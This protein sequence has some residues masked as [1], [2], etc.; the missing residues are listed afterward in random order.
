M[1][2]NR[3]RKIARTAN[4]FLPYGLNLAPNCHN[5]HPTTHPRPHPSSTLAPTLAPKKMTERTQKRT[6]RS[7]PSPTQ[8]VTRGHR[9]VKRFHP[10]GTWAFLGH[11]GP[12]HRSP[13]RGENRVTLTGTGAKKRGH[14]MGVPLPHLRLSGCF[15]PAAEKKPKKSTLEAPFVDPEK[16]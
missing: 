8:R 9:R 13:H 12:N 16:R 10:D 1:P 3:S 14:G 2:V 6:D 4:F 11:D 5:P 7:T 15:R